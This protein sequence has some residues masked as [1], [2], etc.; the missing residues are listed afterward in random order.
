ML[1][2]GTHPPQPRPVLRVPVLHQERPAR[3]GVQVVLALEPGGR[4]GLDAVDG[5][6]DEAVV[7]RGV[8]DRLGVRT[9][10]R[11]QGAEDAVDVLAQS[12]P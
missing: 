5:H 12:S 4:L 11:V 8:D 7:V 9:A 3:V 2:V 6:P 1:A 10:H